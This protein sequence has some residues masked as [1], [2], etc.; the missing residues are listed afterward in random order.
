MTDWGNMRVQIYASDGDPITSLRGDAHKFSKWAQEMVNANPDFVKAYNRVEDLSPLYRIRP[1]DGHHHGRPGP[2]HSHRHQPLQ[3]PGLRQ[4]ERLLGAS[5]QPLIGRGMIGQKVGGG[6]RYPN[7]TL[8]VVA[9]FNIP[10]TGSQR[11]LR[12]R[13]TTRHHLRTHLRARPNCSANRNADTHTAT[14]SPTATPGPTPQP[15]GLLTPPSA[16]LPGYSVTAMSM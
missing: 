3:T 7:S 12:I 13:Y 4:G 5:V 10:R 2:H 16:L 8:K 6:D 1:A 14:S 11:N 15:V 9:L